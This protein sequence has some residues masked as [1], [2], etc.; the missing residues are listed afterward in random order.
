[1]AGNVS[2]VP[3]AVAMFYNGLNAASEL[4]GCSGNLKRIVNLGRHVTHPYLLKT[5]PFTNDDT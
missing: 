2:P 5:A 3:Q 4:F 1:M